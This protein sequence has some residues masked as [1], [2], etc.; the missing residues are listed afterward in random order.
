MCIDSVSK[1]IDECFSITKKDKKTSHK[2]V[3]FWYRGQSKSEYKL[4]PGVYRDTFNVK[5]DK[6]RL[7]KERHLFKDFKSLSSSMISPQVTPEKMYF[8]MQHYG[9][10]TRL[11]DWSSAALVALYFAVKNNSESN[12]SVFILDAYKLVDCQVS[13]KSRFGIASSSRKEYTDSVKHLNWEPNL[14]FPAY[15]FPVS[16]DY[17]DSRIVLQK[18]GFTFHV[19]GEDLIKN[20]KIMNQCLWRIDIKGSSK[21]ELKKDLQSLGVDEFSIYGNLDSLSIS[22]KSRYEDESNF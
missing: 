20:E 10:E 16:G 18:G 7:E 8:L 1:F 6:V 15:T 3:R 17:I 14:Q 19:N 22:I 13:T 4:I 12:G 9:M 5:D 2:N 11:L 21:K